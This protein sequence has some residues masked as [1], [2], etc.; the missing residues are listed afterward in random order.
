MGIFGGL[1]QHVRTQALGWRS[2]ERTSEGKPQVVAL[3]GDRIVTVHAVGVEEQEGRHGLRATVTSLEF[4]AEGSVGDHLGGVETHAPLFEEFWEG[5]S[6][7]KIHPHGVGIAVVGDALGVEERDEFATTQDKLV[8]GVLSLLRNIF[9]V[10]D[11]QHLDL[12]RD[13]VGFHR[14]ALNRE[15]PFEFAESDPRLL[16]LGLTPHLHH[17]GVHCRPS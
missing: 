1:E 10:N 3:T 2:G 5:R 16:L 11:H 7:A 4:A 13:G 8:D 12:I 9:G 14:D 6:T 17:H 15:I